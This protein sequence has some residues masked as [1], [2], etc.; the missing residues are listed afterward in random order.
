MSFRRS[1][2]QGNLLLTR[3]NASGARVAGMNI[4]AK[5][6]FGHLLTFQAGY[7]YNHSRYIEP[8][9]WHLLFPP[10]NGIQVLLP[11][12]QTDETLRY[13]L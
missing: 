11:P 3:T 6:G 2:A 13:K 5:V 9:Q 4:E 7:T 12:L 8:L 1:D 10:E